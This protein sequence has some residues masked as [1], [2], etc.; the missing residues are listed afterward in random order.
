MQQLVQ[1]GLQ[2]LL[3]HDKI[4]PN[5]KTTS[6]F[7]HASCILYLRPSFSIR[8]HSKA[9]KV[10][11]HLGRRC[12]L[13]TCW[14]VYSAQSAKNRLCTN[15]VVRSRAPSICSYIKHIGRVPSDSRTI[16]WLTFPSMAVL[17]QPTKQPS[18]YTLRRVR[19]CRQVWSTSSWSCDDCG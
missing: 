12:G 3:K 2:V 18:Q 4:K 8:S 5:S 10:I 13:W 17:T 19:A 14:C 1:T 9:I 6:N 16:R 15:L 11:K 7:S